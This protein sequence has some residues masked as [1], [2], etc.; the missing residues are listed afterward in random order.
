MQHGQTLSPRK[1]QIQQNIHH[2]NT[3]NIQPNQMEYENQMQHGQTFS[4]QRRS[5]IHHANTANIS[6]NQLE[7]QN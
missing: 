5:N 4:P 6:P 3:T 7:Y 1:R 2:A